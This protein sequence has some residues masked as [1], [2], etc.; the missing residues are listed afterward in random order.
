MDEKQFTYGEITLKY[1]TRNAS[2]DLK[3]LIV[4]FSGIRPDKGY[5][6][7]GRASQSVESNW[8]WIRDEVDAEHTYYLSYKS[9]TDIQEAVLALI[10]NELARLNIGR[11]ECTLVGFSKGGSAALALG[12]RGQFSNIVASVPQIAVG[13]YVKETRPNIMRNMFDT[14]DHSGVHRLDTLIPGLVE[15][16]S[17]T[18]KNIYLWSAVGDKEFAVQVEPYLNIFEKYEN[19]NSLIT[20][21]PLVTAHNEVTKYNLSSIIAVLNLLILG[22][23]PKWGMR[24]NGLVHEQ[25]E[26]VENAGLQ[27]LESSDRS[28]ISEVAEL[29]ISDGKLFP[30]GVLFLKG[31][32]ITGYNQVSKRIV[33]T[34]TNDSLSFKLGELKDKWVN[35]RHYDQNFYDYSFAGFASKSHRGIDLAKIPDGDYKISFELEV[36]GQ[37]YRNLAKVDQF[38]NSMS[39]T[40]DAVLI[41]TSDLSG[42]RLRKRSIFGEVAEA[43]QF[44]V[45]SSWTKDTKVHV[46]GP[47]AVQGITVKRWNQVNY[48]LVLKSDSLVR[49]FTLAA[50][51]KNRVDFRFDNSNS[52]YRAAYFTTPKFAG[53]DLESLPAGNYEAFITM[54]CDDFIFTAR[55]GA[56]MRRSNPDGLSLSVY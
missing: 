19:F 52:S 14:E 23:T 38:S 40:N 10:D 46:E 22:I 50:S 37:K 39:T 35:T 17:N 24:S 2:K 44:K 56:I 27:G 43:S 30:R 54:V 34:S 31:H 32:E 25:A 49:T 51:S 53:I 48:L 4:M 21:S 20:D 42:I 18:K 13:T 41:L 45:L 1:K 16:D 29:Y 28:L 11:N 15:S 26:I 47:F 3:H 7:D 12:I 9:K 33:L 8:L 6:F 55:F 36:D 5:E